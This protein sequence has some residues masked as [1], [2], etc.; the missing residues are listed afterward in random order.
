MTT[1]GG[2]ALLVPVPRP[3]PRG[4]TNGFEAFGIDRSVQATSVD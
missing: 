2:R 4:F 3:F 1:T